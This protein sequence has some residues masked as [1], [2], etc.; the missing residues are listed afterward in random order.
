[1]WTNLIFRSINRAPEVFP[2]EPVQKNSLFFFF[3]VPVLQQVRIWSKPGRLHG[4]TSFN[5]NTPYRRS[6]NQMFLPR[7]EEEEPREVTPPFELEGGVTWAWSKCERALAVSCGGKLRVVSRLRRKEYVDVYDFR[8]EALDEYVG[9]VDLDVEV[10]SLEWGDDVEGAAG[11][12]DS[13]GRDL[14][15]VLLVGRRDG[16]VGIY[17]NGN[18]ELITSIVANEGKILDLIFILE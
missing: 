7:E 14:N 11:G 12:M 17:Q 18:F 6:T 9:K 15:R 2:N 13:Y 3:S 10:T 8:H 1:M 4:T 5:P 16:S